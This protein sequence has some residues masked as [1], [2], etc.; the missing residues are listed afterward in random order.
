[1]LFDIIKAK[2]ILLNHNNELNFNKLI[3]NLNNI[4]II[5]DE[6]KIPNIIHYIF[7]LK[8]Q[9]E[10]FPF[11]YYFGILS[12]ILINNPLKIFFHYEYLPYG[13][14]WDRIKSY[15]VLNYIN[16][17]DLGFKNVKVLHYAHKSDYIRL[18]ILYKYGGIY[19]DIDTLCVK[20]HENLLNNDLILGIQ[21]K[22][23]DEEDLIGK[24][25]IFSK[26]FFYK[27]ID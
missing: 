3:K 21:E 18:L 27:I 10:E 23:K 24:T 11:L 9:N 22:Y 7:G 14:W 4:K 13:Y 17:S 8:E 5:E 20:N 26:K 16:Y 6:K 19:Y 2:K 1:M 12:N 25:V 15:L